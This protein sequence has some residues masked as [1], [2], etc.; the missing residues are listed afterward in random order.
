MI[1]FTNIPVINSQEVTKTAHQ[2]TCFHRGAH[3][4]LDCLG[5]KY[6]ADA[7]QQEHGPVGESP[8]DHLERIIERS[9]QSSQK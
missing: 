1:L 7:S 4:A 9:A 5:K 8:E 6:K 3:A 2:I